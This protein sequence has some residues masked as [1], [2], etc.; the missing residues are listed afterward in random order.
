MVAQELK[1]PDGNLSMNFSV[2]EGGIPTYKLTYKGKDVIKPS[3]LG[4]ELK[5][6]NP[7]A[8]FGT[9]M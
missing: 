9:E 1:S 8:E 6:E 4:L 2:Q 5:D 3:R 7:A